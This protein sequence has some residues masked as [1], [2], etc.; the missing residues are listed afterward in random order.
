M[1]R[2]QSR[3]QTA[4]RQL[5]LTI[6]NKS[7]TSSYNLLWLEHVVNTVPNQHEDK[8]SK[9]SAMDGILLN[10]HVRCTLLHTPCPSQY[11]NMLVFHNFL[12]DI[13]QLPLLSGLAAHEVTGSDL[14]TGHQ[15]YRSFSFQPIS[16]WVQECFLWTISLALLHACSHSVNPC[17]ILP[18][19]VLY[20]CSLK[21]CT[22]AAEKTSFAV[23][24]HMW[25]LLFKITPNDL[26]IEI[27]KERCVHMLWT[28]SP[29]EFLENIQILTR[30]S[31]V[32]NLCFHSSANCQQPT[33]K[34]IHYSTR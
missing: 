12:L 33:T 7:M 16:A 2:K 22:Q 11:D 4:I 27:Q 15:G 10:A 24:H 25:Q 19:I 14:A 13:S 31:A 32:A 29:S 26:R 28:D 9:T 21:P 8:S 6:P 20:A 17:H 30:I 23:M 5:L 18:L 3:R 34:W 1:Q